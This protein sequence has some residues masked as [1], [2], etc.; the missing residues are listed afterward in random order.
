VPG[1]VWSGPLVC[2]VKEWKGQLQAV[3]RR[4]LPLEYEALMCPQVISQE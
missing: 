4:G 1:L 3:V 2:Q